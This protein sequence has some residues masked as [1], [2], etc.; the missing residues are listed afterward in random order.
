MEKT[1]GGL[2]NLSRSEAFEENIWAEIAK[3]GDIDLSYLFDE[4]K[5]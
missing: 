1:T 2:D 5:G 4:W 3:G